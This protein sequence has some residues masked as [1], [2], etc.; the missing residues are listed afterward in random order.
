MIKHYINDKDEYILEQDG[1][2]VL[3]IA[4]DLEYNAIKAKT[5]KEVYEGDPLYI[6]FTGDI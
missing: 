5:L 1:V 4:L 3:S 2:I 6:T